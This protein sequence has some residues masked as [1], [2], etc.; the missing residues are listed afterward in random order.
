MTKSQHI[1]R[2]KGE[3]IDY[4][5]AVL[6]TM[7]ECT[8]G[9]WPYTR[10]RDGYAKIAWEGQSIKVH[11]LVCTWFHGPPPPGMQTRHLCG[12]GHLGCFSPGCLTWGTPKEQGEDQR[13]HGRIRKGET[14]PRA[15]LTDEQV[16]EIR[17]RYEGSQLNR[18]TG[19][20]QQALANEYGVSQA[21]IS[22]ILRGVHRPGGFY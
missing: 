7:P 9:R 15:V 19:P 22:Q 1:R 14:S 8:A 20:S 5:Y 11:R 17:R 3:Q 10:S 12:L 18:H 4:L 21:L 16:A 13:R 6:T 2:P